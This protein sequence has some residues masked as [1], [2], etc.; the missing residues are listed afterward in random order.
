MVMGPDSR[1]AEGGTVPFAAPAKAGR[2]QE[3]FFSL[4]R[5]APVS[6]CVV[7]LER[8]GLGDW[9]QSPHLRNPSCRLLATRREW[10]LGNAATPTS[11]DF[12]R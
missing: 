10:G 5:P 9:R 8:R 12:A 11:G 4:F 6:A 3:T 2:G 7:R 1:P